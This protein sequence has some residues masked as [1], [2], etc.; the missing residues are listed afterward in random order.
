MFIDVLTL[1]P[2]MF[3]FVLSDSIL[4]RAQER[5]IVAVNLHNLRKWTFD[6]R[7]TVDDRPFGG[8]PGMVLKPEPIF[9]ALD[10]LKKNDSY[11]ILLSPGG[12]RL[13]QNMVKRLSKKRHLILISGHY[14]GVDE[15]V[16][17]Y[18]VDLEVSIGDYILTCGELPAMVV[19]DSVVRVLPDVIG[20]KDAHISE[21][22][23]NN[24]LEY[25]QYTR[26]ENY[27]GFK[28]PGVLLD[29]NHKKIEAFRLR[30]A[31]K[32]TK[33]VRPDL[34]KKYIISVK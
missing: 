29:G 28:V 18:G 32:K 1:F 6:K 23:E 20:N 17:E 14:E 3:K 27:R 16:K 26:P 8:G 19:I 33:K 24:L 4:K 34:Y 12:K 10:E 15:R 31:E 11:V 5:N 2:E 22:F 30:E 9:K 25:P 21:S 7:K 13:N